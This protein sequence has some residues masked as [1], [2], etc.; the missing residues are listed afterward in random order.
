MMKKIMIIVLSLVMTINLS[1]ADEGMWLLSLLNKMNLQSKGLMLTPEQIYSINN[2]SLKDAVVGL[3]SAGNPFGFFCTGEIVSG[4]GLILTNHHCGFSSIQSHSTPEH[5]YLADGFWARSI[6]EELINEGTTASILIRIE[7]VTTKVSAELNDDMTETERNKAIGEI[8]KKIKEEATKDSDYGSSVK[9]MFGGNQFFLFVYETFLDIRLVGAPPS[10]IGKFGGD[11]DNWMWPRHTGDFSMFRIY[12][13]ADGK[14][15]KYSKDNIPL[16]PRH[17]FPISLKGIQDNDFAMVMGFPGS[18]DRYLTSYGIKEALDISNPTR[19]KIRDKKLKIM[20]EGMDSSQKIRIQYAAKYAQTANYWKY[21]IGQSKGLKKLKVYEEKQELENKIT[22]WINA[23]EKRKEKYGEALKLIEE[24]YNLK[25]EYVKTNAY[26]GEAV[27]Q[28][29]EV[30]LFSYRSKAIIDVLKNS[31]DDQAA[32]DELIKEKLEAS[33]D[34]FKDYNAAIDEKLLVA[35]L[36]MLSKDVPVDKQPDFL[37]EIN[38]KYK[39][40]FEKFASKLF[41]KSIFTNQERFEAFLDNPKIKPIE[42]D[43]AFKL[44]NSFIKKYIELRGKQGGFSKKL[45]KGNRL[46]IAALL[47][48]DKAHSSDYY[49]NANSTLRLT[50]GTVGDYFPR[51]AV[52]YDYFTTLKGYIEKED[53]NSLEFVV[54]DKL[55]ELYYKQDFGKYAMKNGEMPVCF[56]TNND[57][58]GGNSGSPV[59]NANGE[60][61]GIAFDGNWEAMSGDIE[62]EDQLQ[63]CINV[64]IRYVMFIIDKYAGAKN[65]IKEMKLIENKP[66]PVKHKLPVGM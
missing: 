44:V 29:A 30:L 56:T 26:Y 54:P 36:K 40:D 11:T 42:K 3:G 39:G 57:I 61:I 18:T 33:K 52:H 53:P 16:K 31:K 5:D 64:D 63:K 43:P 49:P 25:K 19:I 23:D 50:Y 34:Y 45:N 55:K 6:E 35:M 32:I 20:K 7:D 2:S 66:V 48:M 21:F 38:K 65:L 28:G 59:L 14:P 47:E 24:A 22:K 37:I 17:F 51:D 41:K 62:F 10:S 1:R 8:A 9:P 60:L 4:K 46:F 13:G 15:A 58:T 27:F 12:S